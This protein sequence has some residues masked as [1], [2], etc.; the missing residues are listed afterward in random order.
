MVSFRGRIDE[1]DEG[2]CRRASRFLLALDASEARVAG[3]ACRDRV[4]GRTQRKALMVR[5]VL[6]VALSRDGRL[7]DRAGETFAARGSW[8]HAGP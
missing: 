4:G 5:G 1:N 8:S 2:E 6:V 7:F 3:R